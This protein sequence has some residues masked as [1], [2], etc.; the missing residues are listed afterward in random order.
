MASVLSTEDE[1]AAEGAPP[2]TLVDEA[3]PPPSV[4]DTLALLWMISFPELPPTLP[5][6]CPPLGV[7]SSQCPLSH[8]FPILTIP[9][10][11]VLALRSMTPFPE[12]LPTLL[13]SRPLLGS[14][15]PVEPPR[16]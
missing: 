5:P 8:L 12:L 3:P 14:R 11:T 6:S 4:E 15:S 16:A 1:Q 13:L 10:D 7:L 2:Y 9:F